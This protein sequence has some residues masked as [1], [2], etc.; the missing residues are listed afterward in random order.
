MS[1]IKRH[2]VAEQ[3]RIVVYKSLSLN[4]PHAIVQ[5][6]PDIFDDA[7]EFYRIKH[8]LFDRMRRDDEL[9]ERYGE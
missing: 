6:N 3:E 5:R 9:R 1:P 2:I 4:L 7:R 8:N